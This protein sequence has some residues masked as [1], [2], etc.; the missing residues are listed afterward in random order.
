MGELEKVKDYFDIFLNQAIY[1]ADE[2][3]IFAFFLR[4]FP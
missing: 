2:K 1:Q 4:G 3:A